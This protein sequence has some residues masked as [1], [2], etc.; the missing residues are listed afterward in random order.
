MRHTGLVSLDGQLVTR[1]TAMSLPPGLPLAQ[2]R[3]LGR[4]MFVVADS[5]AWW[6]GDW[7]IYG[8]SEYPDRYRRALAETGLDYQTLRNYAW[9]A[10]KYAP[11]ER[12]ARLS[13][14]HHAE[15]AGMPVAERDEWLSRAERGGWSRNELRRRLRAHRYSDRAALDTAIRISVPRDR[16]VRWQRAAE[17][18]G[19]DLLDWM[20]RRLDEAAD[21]PADSDVPAASRT[22]SPGA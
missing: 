16:G 12:R 6:M 3:H 4:Q 9:V 15:V 11:S 18:A 13:F 22:P 21:E 2:W 1:R 8:R 14:Q 7:L 17:A 10:G 20:V 5:S 19:L